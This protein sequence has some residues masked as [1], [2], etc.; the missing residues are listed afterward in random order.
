MAPLN[1]RLE[2]AVKSVPA[3]VIAG[4]FKGFDQLFDTFWAGF[5]NRAT[6]PATPSVASQEPRS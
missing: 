3:A 1:Q 6:I 5:E 2:I 4:H